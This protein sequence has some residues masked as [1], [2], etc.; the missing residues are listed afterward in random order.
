IPKKLGCC[1]RLY[2]MERL[3]AEGFFFHRSCFQCFHCRNTLRLAAYAFDQ[4]SGECL[5]IVIIKGGAGR[6]G[7]GGA[8]RGGLK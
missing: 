4:H 7:R 8:G 6:G 3:S 1:K 2:V 5:S